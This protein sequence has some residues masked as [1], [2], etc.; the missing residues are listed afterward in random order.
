MLSPLRSPDFP[1]ALAF[2]RYEETEKTATQANNHSVRFSSINSHSG[3]VDV[4]DS[5]TSPATQELQELAFDL[6]GPTSQGIHCIPVQQQQN[7]S[8][9]GIFSVALQQA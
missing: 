7:S 4:Y 1:L 6:T 5:L 8:D 9:C 2:S 3:Y